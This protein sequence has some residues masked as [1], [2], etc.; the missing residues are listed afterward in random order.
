MQSPINI[1]N[2]STTAANYS[3]FAFS[4]GYKTVMM[5]TISNTGYAS[6]LY[7][8]WLKV[9]LHEPRY[10]VSLSQINFCS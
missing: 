1:E 4:V 2:N 6:M 5:G 3:D 10:F 9:F 7:S 8:S